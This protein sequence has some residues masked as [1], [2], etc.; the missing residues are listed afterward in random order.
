MDKVE[1]INGLYD[2]SDVFK[3]LLAVPYGLYQGYQDRSTAY[4]YVDNLYNKIVDDY[5]KGLGGEKNAISV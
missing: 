4:D 5:Q 2:L 3:Y 1:Q